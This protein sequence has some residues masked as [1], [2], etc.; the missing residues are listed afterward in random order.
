[1]IRALSSLH[2]EAQCAE[3]ITICPPSFSL[4]RM[5]VLSVS[6]S[7]GERIRCSQTAELSKALLGT[8]VGVKRDAES[9]A[10]MFGR[11]AALTSHVRVAR[12]RAEAAGGPPSLFR[13]PPACLRTALL[14]VCLASLPS[15]VL[16]RPLLI[17]LR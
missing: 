13:L 3:L 7:P 16:A 15:C 17:C 14:R 5:H 8:E 11:M 4:S 9:V 2:C 6:V 10:A 12:E 1:M